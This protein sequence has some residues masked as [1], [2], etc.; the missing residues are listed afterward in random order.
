VT[1][2][3]DTRDRGLQ[4]GTGAG[5]LGEDGI[6]LCC[7]LEGL[8]LAVALC[9]P[10]LDCGLQIGNALED[11]APDALARDLGKQALD[12]VEPGRGGRREALPG[13]RWHAASPATSGHRTAVQ[14]AEPGPCACSLRAKPRCIAR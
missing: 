5:V 14:C 9:D 1:H 12:E 4:S 2:S 13:S 11:A 10:S 7:P 3:F 6:G 8:R